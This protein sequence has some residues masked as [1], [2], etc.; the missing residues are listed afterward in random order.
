MTV[1]PTEDF[2]VFTVTGEHGEYRVDLAENDGIGHCNCPDFVCRKQKLIT[3]GTF[4]ELDEV[5]CRHIRWLIPKVWRSHA[6]QMSRQRDK[7]TNKHQ[8][9]D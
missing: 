6:R 1:K 5:Q 8:H 2:L 4:T 7:I 9:H 3:A